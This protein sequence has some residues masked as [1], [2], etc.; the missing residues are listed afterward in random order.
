MP[1]LLQ[2]EVRASQ[3]RPVASGMRRQRSGHLG[4]VGRRGHPVE[5]KGE[6]CAP[7][8]ELAP[9]S[10]PGSLEAWMVA[11]DGS[12]PSGAGREEA[13][14]RKLAQGHGVCSGQ[15]DPESTM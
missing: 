10:L 9:Q 11:S 14:R 2:N 4:V 6:V 3:A 1:T 8:R 13:H 7:V 15:P 12:L 5:A